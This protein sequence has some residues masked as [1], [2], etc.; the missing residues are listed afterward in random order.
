MVTRDELLAAMDLSPIIANNERAGLARAFQDAG[1]L[2]E[3]VAM[4][5]EASKIMLKLNEAGKP[6]REKSKGR[7]MGRDLGIWE[8]YG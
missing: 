1:R 2:G 7:G 6:R 5:A 8:I 4:F 3:L